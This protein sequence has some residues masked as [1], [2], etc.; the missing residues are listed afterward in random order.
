LCGGVNS[1]IGFSV[2]KS[3][4]KVWLHLESCSK[5]RAGLTEA[6][7]VPEDSPTLAP[8]LSLFNVEVGGINI[9]KHGNLE[10]KFG[11]CQFIEIDHDRRYEAWQIE[12]SSEEGDFILVCPP[13]GEV[14]RFE[15]AGRSRGAENLGL[16]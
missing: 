1:A 7:L 13:G 5:L 6:M 16:H 2:G 9:S 10:V 12:G 4:D 15:D 11:D 14:V 8:V 3:E